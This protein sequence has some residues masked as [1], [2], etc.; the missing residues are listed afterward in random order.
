MKR[1]YCIT[2]NGE[3]YLY[4]LNVLQAYWIAAALF[5]AG[6]WRP[7]KRVRVRNQGRQYYNAF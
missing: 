5:I 7:S 3:S 6:F 4:D 2:I 1:H